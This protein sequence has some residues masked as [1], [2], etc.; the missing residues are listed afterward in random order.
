[1]SASVSLTLRLG[2]QCDLRIECAAESFGHFEVKSDPGRDDIFSIGLSL[3]GGNEPRR[4][5]SQVNQRPDNTNGRN[6]VDDPNG[7]R[8]GVAWQNH[9]RH[10]GIPPFAQRAEGRQLQFCNGTTLTETA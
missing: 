1:M 9:H 10:S 5:E 7:D 6:P 4:E 2:E 8:I 3:H